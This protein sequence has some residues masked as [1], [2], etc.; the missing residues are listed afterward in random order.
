MFVILSAAKNLPCDGRMLH[1]FDF[2]QDR[3]VQHDNSSNKLRQSDIA[4]AKAILKSRPVPK[5][6]GPIGPYV[7]A[8]W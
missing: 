5:P 7:E 3:F 4:I 2:T 1:S 8:Q 6:E